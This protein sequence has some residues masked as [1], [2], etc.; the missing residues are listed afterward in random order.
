[1]LTFF[2]YQFVNRLENQL[3]NYTVCID[4]FVIMSTTTEGTYNI[5]HSKALDRFLIFIPHDSV[6]RS[7]V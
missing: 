6:T 4:Y 1:M 5:Q 3:I 7:H 2:H